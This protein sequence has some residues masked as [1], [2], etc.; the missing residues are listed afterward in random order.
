VSTV[1][2]WGEINS[3]A[4]MQNPSKAGRWVRCL[5][6]LDQDYHLHVFLSPDSAS[7]LVVLPLLLIAVSPDTANGATRSIVLRMAEDLRTPDVSDEGLPA[8]LLKLTDTLV[9]LPHGW[10]HH[11][12]AIAGEQEPRG[13]EQGN[14]NREAGQ[15]EHR[16]G[17]EDGDDVQLILDVEDAEVTL[18][19]MHPTTALGT[20][21]SQGRGVDIR[22]RDDEVRQ[23]WLAL[24]EVATSHDKDLW[25]VGESLQ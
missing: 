7:S 23:E 18:P 2:R 22:F 24:L 4:F 5:L 6:V 17:P 9:N 25:P 16:A 3:S 13:G 11:A 14:E 15:I 20:L 21:L 10:L 8:D 12:A 19:A 1:H